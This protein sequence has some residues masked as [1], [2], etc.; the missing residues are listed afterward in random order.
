MFIS[1]VDLTQLFIPLLVETF[2]TFLNAIWFCLCLLAQ[3]AERKLGQASIKIDLFSY[4]DRKEENLPLTSQ[5]HES[6][7]L[8][9]NVFD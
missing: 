2:G 5:S 8:T 3:N 9:R 1:I 7:V 6:N 4:S